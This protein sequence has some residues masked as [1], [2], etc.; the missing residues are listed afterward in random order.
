MRFLSSTVYIATLLL[1]NIV[2]ASSGIPLM[3]RMIA[4]NPGLH[5]YEAAIH[6]DIS[7]KTFPFLSPSLDG[8]YYHK[9]PSLDK[10]VFTS[11]LPTMAAEF[12]KV[13]PRVPSP[14]QWSSIYVIKQ[15]RDDGN[16]TAFKLV[17]RKQG[18]VDHIDVAVDDA[19]ATI[20]SMRWDYND[21]GY[22]ELHQTYSNIDGNLVVTGQTGHFE[23]SL[24]KADVSSTLSNYKLNPPLSDSFFQN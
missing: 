21:G 14:A 10:I 23:S 4:L 11:G 7:M 22:A 19:S 3:E 18:R 2:P 9:A 6:A 12:S 5:S 16:V 13:Y 17:P 24:Y 15:G 1:A 8:T 20:L